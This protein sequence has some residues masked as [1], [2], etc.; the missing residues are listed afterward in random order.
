MQT[1]ETVL[2]LLEQVLH[3]FHEIC[4]RV[5]LRFLLLWWRSHLTSARLWPHLS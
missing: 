1:R 3:L 5:V 4:V 2:K